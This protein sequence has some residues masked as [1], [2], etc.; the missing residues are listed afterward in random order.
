MQK[1]FELIKIIDSNLV[2]YEI[3]KVALM[4]SAAMPD[5]YPVRQLFAIK[6]K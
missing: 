2:L 1:L 3:F 4:R 6:E 5:V